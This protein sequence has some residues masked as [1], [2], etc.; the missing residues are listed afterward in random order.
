MDD[1]EFMESRALRASH[2]GRAC[3]TCQ[4]FSDTADTHWHTLLTCSL[5]ERL[6]PHGENPTKRCRHWTDRTEVGIGLVPRGGEQA[7]PGSMPGS[8]QIMHDL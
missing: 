7:M 2:S 4:H 3:I 8:M 6:I 5:R 1:W